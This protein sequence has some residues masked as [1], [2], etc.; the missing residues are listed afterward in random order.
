MIKS[1]LFA[2]L[3][4]AALLPRPCAAAGFEDLQTARAGALTA[5]GT[6]QLPVSPPDGPGSFRVTD[7]A[8]LLADLS[9]HLDYR[10]SDGQTIFPYAMRNLRFYRLDGWTRHLL[11]QVDDHTLPR[12]HN[13][14]VLALAG[15]GETAYT[16]LYAYDSEKEREP[17]TAATVP[18]KICALDPACARINGLKKAAEEKTRAATPS[19][20]APYF[21][22]ARDALVRRVQAHYDSDK[23]L[24]LD[25]AEVAE[26]KARFARL[27]AAAAPAG[28]G[29]ASLLAA[30]DGEWRL[31]HCGASSAELF[32]RVK[33]A[34]PDQQD[35]ILL[36]CGLVLDAE[37][38]IKNHY[39]N[40]ALAGLETACAAGKAGAAYCPVY[41]DW[42]RLYPVKTG[43][44]ELA[45]V[46]GKLPI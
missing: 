45:L 25:R 1:P 18:E 17:Y 27:A 38:L 3:A 40:E 42:A 36:R 30:N 4:F 10:G 32:E 12:F 31:E 35:A 20:E 21:A 2:L 11:V 29:K 43:L 9:A 19:W 5:A 34:P 24:K 13:F 41:R 28:N 15:A 7:N 8:P 6:E 44:T 14:L 37:W 26:A 23:F 46:S 33:A 22:G 16:R 39:E